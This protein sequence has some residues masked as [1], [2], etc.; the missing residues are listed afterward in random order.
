MAP[1]E[2]TEI[3]RAAA[4]IDGVVAIDKTIEWLM[5]DDK[6]QL[7]QHG[8]KA[9]ESFGRNR[10]RHFTDEQLGSI[11]RRSIVEELL[12]EREGVV[13]EHGKVVQFPS[14]PAVIASLKEQQDEG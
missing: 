2:A 11:V 9:R 12:L 6:A 4:A 1:L 13:A 3:K 10:L 7:A 14:P 5:K 8:Q